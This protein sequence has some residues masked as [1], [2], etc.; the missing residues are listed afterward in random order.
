[1]NKANTIKQLIIVIITANSL[2][3]TLPLSAMRPGKVIQKITPEQDMHERMQELLSA[4][5]DKARNTYLDMWEQCYEHVNK[6]N[7]VG[8]TPLMIAVKENNQE[9]VELLL[10]RLANPNIA[11]IGELTPL[12]EAAF[13]NNSTMTEIL[14]NQSENINLN[15][16]NT[17][18]NTALLIA[19]QN[20]NSPIVQTLIAAGADLKKRNSNYQTALLIAAQNNYLELMR[21]LIAA[22]PTSEQ[23]HS[24]LRIA[25]TKN[26]FEIAEI[27]VNAGADVN[28][29]DENIYSLR[30]NTNGCSLLMTAASHGNAAMVKML[31]EHEADVD[32]V[33]PYG[34]T[35]L[36]RATD[37]YNS[38]IV[39]ML[40]DKSIAT[41]N[42]ADHRGKTPLLHALDQSA[43]D[44]ATL[45]IHHG[46]DVKAKDAL[47]TSALQATVK[48]YRTHSAHGADKAS[49]LAELLI[50][51]GAKYLIDL[52]YPFKHMRTP[53]TIAECAKK[54]QFPLGKNVQ[55]AIEVRE[56]LEQ[57]DYQLEDPTIWP[58]LPVE[59]TRIG[60]ATIN[61]IAQYGYLHDI[62]LHNPEAY[63]MALTALKLRD[64]AKKVATTE[65]QLAE[66]R[67]LT[68]KI[69]LAK[70]CALEK[71]PA[72]QTLST[73]SHT[74][75]SPQ[76]Q[77]SSPFQKSAIHP[78]LHHG[79]Q[80]QCTLPFQRAEDSDA[81]RT[82]ACPS[83]TFTNSA[84]AHQC[85]MCMTS[86][87]AHPS[88]HQPAIDTPQKSVHETTCP[89]CTFLNKAHIVRCEMC[90]MPL[91]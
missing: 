12:M 66:K 1:M 18:G 17:D 31:I 54:N 24:A 19:A 40:L 46:A 39:R 48:A 90:A 61:L 82:I 86:L 50:L 3:L 65:A 10:Q 59:F 34:I 6:K 57:E 81:A 43:S 80:L 20:N 42:Q 51:A 85:E 2:S 14:I 35:A 67:A 9:V 32:I 37:K 79:E 71:E 41:I 13:Q 89:Q 26:H 53:Q 72:M 56:Q 91:I 69:T 15:K 63:K 62:K 74:P 38:E 88:V 7:S 36:L 23:I 16:T 78:S 55:D 44:I 11:N 70:K 68:E 5:N 21:T 33:S 87:S 27:C 73:P 60:N 25:V 30:M 77:S 29:L 52:A 8:N 28:Q 58:Q 4:K 83:C 84:R 64:Q 75:F 45:L 49:S 47:N 76:A 22:D